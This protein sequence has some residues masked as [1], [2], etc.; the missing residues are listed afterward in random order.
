MIGRKS[1]IC[2][3]RRG[4]ELLIINSR[5]CQPDAEIRVGLLLGLLIDSALTSG[6][7]GGSAGTA[8]L[9]WVIRNQ[10]VQPR[11]K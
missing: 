6:S 9:E 10:P 8:L 1:S 5:V 11:Q 4:C 7:S 3:A 2:F